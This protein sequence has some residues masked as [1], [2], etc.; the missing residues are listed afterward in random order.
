MIQPI[1]WHARAKAIA[2]EDE[3]KAQRERAEKLQHGVQ[4]AGGT[5]PRNKRRQSTANR[6]DVHLSAPSPLRL[7]VCLW[8]R[9]G[10][11]FL[12][13]LSTR[14][15][16][17]KRADAPGDNKSTAADDDLPDPARGQS[18]DLTA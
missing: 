15:G 4:H 13:N 3:D 17:R 10:V 11:R 6:N 18:L 5:T 16:A 7:P 9:G 8:K 12:M 14:G 2:N 1:D